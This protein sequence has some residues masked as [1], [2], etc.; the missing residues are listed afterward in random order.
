LFGIVEDKSIFMESITR[1][2]S[3]QL[4]VKQI[5]MLRAMFN[6]IM[7][8]NYKFNELKGFHFVA[9]SSLSDTIY[10]FESLF[11]YLSENHPN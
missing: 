5:E 7:E 2:R 9:Q 6:V 1:A 11:A 3:L 10:E 4:Y 8:K